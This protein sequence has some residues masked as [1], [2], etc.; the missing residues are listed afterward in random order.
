MKKI[1]RSFLF[2][3]ILFLAIALVGCKKNEEENNGGDNKPEEHVHSYTSYFH[4]E[5]CEG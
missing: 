5:V 4:K 1:I 3:F 2:V